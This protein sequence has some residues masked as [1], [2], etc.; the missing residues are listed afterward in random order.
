[1]KIEKIETS[2]I[3]ELENKNIERISVAI[4]VFDGVHL[5]HR[6]LIETLKNVALRTN[7]EPVVLT[8]FPHPRE[9]LKPNEKVLL[10]TTQEKKLDIIHS[11]GIR[12]IVTLHFT[13]EFA[14]LAPSQFLEKCLSTKKISL[15]GICV[16]EK[17][18][19]GNAGHGNINTIRE[20]CHSNN[21]A[22]EPVPELVIDGN[23]VS[24]TLIRRYISS[25]LIQPAAK[26]L[27]RRHSLCGIVEHGEKIASK[28][29]DCPTA[30]I[31]VSHGII[32]PNGVYAGFAYLDGHKYNCAISIGTAPSVIRSHPQKILVEAFLFDFNADIYGKP[33][34]IE[35]Y[36]YLREE[37][38][39]PSM[40]ALKQQIA[41][42]LQQIRG[43]L[44]KEK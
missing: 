36:D 41:I 11:L 24:S 3:M 18:K 15:C 4:G 1:M 7:S 21:I 44:E 26:L 12:T 29:L 35:F 8:F 6:R 37:R 42:D 34:E 27:G 2:S 16:G 13:K 23:I 5:G 22:F 30:N 31:A 39:F 40:E 19:F 9:I 17:W 10:L 28:L 14:M 43:I 25:G 32:P 20:F 38:V 33:I